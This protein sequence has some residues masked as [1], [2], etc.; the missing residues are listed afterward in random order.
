MSK[1]RA[2]PVRLP[3]PA[4]PGADWADAFEIG[5]PESNVS[6]IDAARRALGSMPGWV[7]RLMAVR[8]ALARLVGL[9]AGPD[10]GVGPGQKIGIFP[11]LAEDPKRVVLGL[12]DWHLDFR[13]VVEVEHDKSEG[14]LLRATTLVHRKSLFGRL[15]IGL[16]APFHRVIVPTAL[17]S[18][19]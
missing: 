18:A 5:L 14:T 11:I 10:G 4:L 3:D 8:N 15:Y 9:K 1:T 13:L 2:V 16:V 7:R 19:L 17:R 6:A 12:D